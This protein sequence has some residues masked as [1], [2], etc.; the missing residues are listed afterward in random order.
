MNRGTK[1]EQTKLGEETLKGGRQQLQPWLESFGATVTRVVLRT[2]FYPFLLT[3]V[4][5]TEFTEVDD[6]V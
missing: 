5:F 1:P 4:S 6:V 3:F 2:S